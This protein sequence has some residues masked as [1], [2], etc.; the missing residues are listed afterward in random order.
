MS[1]SLQKDSTKLA[2]ENL[3]I[4]EQMGKI[5]AENFNRKQQ[6]DKVNILSETMS[7]K[8]G[9]TKKS[10]LMNV[11]EGI[12]R[13]TNQLIQ[14]QAEKSEDA[15]LRVMG[16]NEDTLQANQKGISK[17][18][19]EAFKDMREQKISTLDTSRLES[20]ISSMDTNLSSTLNPTSLAQGIKYNLDNNFNV[21]SI[22][23]IDNPINSKLDSVSTTLKSFLESS[24]QNLGGKVDSIVRLL[25]G[26]KIVTP[27]S[28]DKSI[29]E[30]LV[31][32]IEG[33]KDMDETELANK[34][35][36]VLNT[37]LIDTSNEL[38]RRFGV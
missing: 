33:T 19:A 30:N 26:N 1:Y 16:L 29:I 17:N 2:I 28:K 21:N 27:T 38:L 15:L 8:A 9:A 10:D 32:N 14:R 31:I 18:F 5:D 12:L 24:L 37:E 23:P 35:V 4:Q 20:A 3:G 36:E 25:T 22:L 34:I 6:M 13:P 7:S 11:I